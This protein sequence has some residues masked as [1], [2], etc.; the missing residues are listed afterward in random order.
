MDFYNFHIRH[1]VAELIKHLVPH[2]AVKMFVYNIEWLLDFV[3]CLQWW[4]MWKACPRAEISSA[5]SWA[6]GE[7]SKETSLW[8]KMLI[9]EYFCLVQVRMNWAAS[10]WNAFNTALFKHTSF[11]PFDL[12]FYFVQEGAVSTNQRIFHIR[13][14]TQSS[15]GWN[16]ESE[17]RPHSSNCITTHD[18]GG[19]NS[20]SGERKVLI[21]SLWKK[22]T[23]KATS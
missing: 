5:L 6:P 19:N 2:L 23:K 21:R 1:T 7:D 17:V 12:F 20:R 22:K 16:L 13:P 3:R 15:T 10:L 8:C 14:D 9:S 11:L 18:R 4:C